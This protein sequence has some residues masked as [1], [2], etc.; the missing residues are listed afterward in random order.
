MKASDA[1]QRAQTGAAPPTTDSHSVWIAASR[2]ALRSQMNINGDRL[3]KIEFDE[4][5]RA[6]YLVTR[7]CT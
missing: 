3:G 6:V 4:D 2:R 5:L 1:L 7:H